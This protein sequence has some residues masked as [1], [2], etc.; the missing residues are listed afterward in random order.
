MLPHNLSGVSKERIGGYVGGGGV[1]V[2]KVA[3]RTYCTV[4]EFFET[5]TYFTAAVL[6]DSC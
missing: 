2:F 1:L 4:L 6:T 3:Q 5:F